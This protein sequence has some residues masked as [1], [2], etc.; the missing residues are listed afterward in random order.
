MPPIKRFSKCSVPDCTRPYLAKGYCQLHYKRVR[1]GNGVGPVGSMRPPGKLCAVSECGRKHAANGYCSM[2]NQRLQKFGEVGP[3][4]ALVR[5]GEGILYK[6][7]YRLLYRPAS[8][9]RGEADYISEHRLVMS[10][11]LG[12]ALTNKE[13]VHHKNG[14]K[15]DNRPGN[16]ELWTSKYQPSGQRVADRIADAIRILSEYSKDPS[17]WP[18]GTDQFRKYIRRTRGLPT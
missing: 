12:R 8:Q 15:V 17:L 7:G 5:R 9:F 16:L 14:D 13:S 6:N 18:A 2:H 11:V 10:E 1:S 4:D 3:V